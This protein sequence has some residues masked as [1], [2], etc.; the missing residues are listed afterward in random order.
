MNIERSICL[1]L[2]TLTITPVFAQLP[3]D[4]KRKFDEAE[5][6]IVRLP[7]TG[8]QELRVLSASLRDGS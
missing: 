3:E 8:F 5:R 1:G 6:R 2:L 7:P 4:Q